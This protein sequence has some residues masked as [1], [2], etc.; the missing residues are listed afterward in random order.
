MGN[1]PGIN[2]SGTSQITT[3]K[4]ALN[5]VLFNTIQEGQL[6]AI[7]GKVRW[8]NVQSPL[9]IILE[10]ETISSGQQLLLVS[11][12]WGNA[13]VTLDSGGLVGPTTVYVLAPGNT[14]NFKY[15]GVNFNLF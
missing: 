1:T 15:D 11:T 14:Q 12:T 7:L 4:V 3:V 8:I 9:Q 2:V 13:Q 10:A 6:Q 5:N